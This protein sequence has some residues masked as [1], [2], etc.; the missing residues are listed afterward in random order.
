MKIS[1]YSQIKVASRNDGFQ[2]IS[3]KFTLDTLLFN[4]GEMISN[5]LLIKNNSKDTLRFTIDITHPAEWKSLLSNDK[6]FLILSGDS[7]YIPVRLLPKHTIKGSTRYFLSAFLTNLQGKNI[8]YAYFFAYTVKLVKWELSTQPGNKLYFLN[9]ENTLSFS[10]NVINTG[11]ENQDI[12]MQIKDLSYNTLLLDTNEKRI[13]KTIFSFRLD[14]LQDTSMHFKFQ[15]EKKPENYKRID[16]DYYNP[17]SI[18]EGKKYS[19][20]VQTKD[21]LTGPLSKGYTLGKKIEFIRLSDKIKVNDW[22]GAVLPLVMELNAY[23]LLN[24]VPMMNLDLR[25]N[26]MIGKGRLEYSTMFSYT[27]NYY[28][29]DVILDAPF[30]VSYSRENLSASIGRFGNGLGVTGMYNFSRNNSVSANYTVGPHLN[31]IDYQALGINHYFSYPLNNKLV[32]SVGI[33]TGLLNASYNP[34]QVTMQRVSVTPVVYIYKFNLGATVS[35]QRTL[36]KQNDS[37][38]YLTSYGLHGGYVDNFFNNKFRVNA[39]GQ[40]YNRPQAVINS[41]SVGYANTYQSLY[42]N[43]PSY[44]ANSQL[45]YLFNKNKR[46]NF[47]SNYDANPVYYNSV[48]SQYNKYFQN[49]L[50]YSVNV[51]KVN[52]TSGLFYHLYNVAGFKTHSRGVLLNSSKFDFLLFTRTYLSVNFGYNWAPS[53]S[54][55]NYFFLSQSLMTQYKTFY[56]QMFYTLGDVRLVPQSYVLKGKYSQTINLSVRY[57]YI[58]PIPNFVLELRNSYMYSSITGHSFAF[59]P[60]LYYFTRNGWRFRV[61]PEYFTSYKTYFNTAESYYMPTQTEVQKVQAK[62]YHSFNLSVGIRKEFGIPIPYIKSL[63]CTP[64]FLAYMDINGNMEYDKGEQLLENVVIR[65]DEYEV[66]TNEKGTAK[67]ENIGVGNHQI[68]TYSLVD[69][70]GWFPNVTDSVMLVVNKPQYIP[71][72][73]GIKI[74][75]GV[76]VE[77]EQYGA[78][79]DAPLDLSKIKINANN[80]KVHTALTDNKGN[81]EMYLPYGKYTLTFDESILGDRFRLIENNYELTIDKTVDNLYIPFYIVE[82]KRKISIKKFDEKGIEDSPD[83]KKKKEAEEKLRKDEEEK[84]RRIEP[85]EMKKEDELKNKKMTPAE[86]K[87]QAELEKKKKFEEEQLKKAELE[88]QKK[89]DLEN[90]KKLEEDKKIQEELD[91]KNKAKADSLKNASGDNELKKNKDGVIDLT[92]KGEV[93]NDDIKNLTDAILK[94]INGKGDKSSKGQ[95]TDTKKEDKKEDKKEE[96]AKKNIADLKNLNRKITKDDF[97]DIEIDGL[98]HRVQVAASNAEVP[99]SWLK[100]QFKIKGDVYLFKNDD[101]MYNYCLGDFT[102]KGEAVRYNEKLAVQKKVNSFI[103][104]YYNNKRVPYKVIEQ[105]YQSIIDQINE[106]KNTNSQND[107]LQ[108]QQSDSLKQL[109]KDTI[110]LMKD[111]LNK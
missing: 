6:Q 100:N 67:F 22:G 76:L 87:K 57:Q 66:I 18:E 27:K 110:K 38:D 75:G 46:I 35:G 52:F 40:F 25:G 103:S 101:G 86:K 88:K 89:L 41:F 61:S 47:S 4:K 92:A 78:T 10:T 82:K 68:I 106:E 3:C 36:Y 43:L 45:E 44:R 65:V 60:E 80:G 34:T 85:V 26:T 11:N 102:T 99:T 21:P 15:Y 37:T 62:F 14:P 63:F 33:N 16:L 70:E 12:V 91:K 72:S 17:F 105:I 83:L 111:T 53:L 31:N 51:N 55:K 48:S 58:F 96:V 64:E 39:S 71:F 84:K 97:L 81:Y 28:T 7:L 30:M 94:K 56:F 73:K 77:R 5:T 109:M 54:T 95:K 74:Y 49:Q 59:V 90:K 2:E 1:A 50:N 108:K 69:L 24:D 32:K 79:V 98:L 8:S 20:F 42:K 19:L 9:G 13:K 104:Y 107:N 93:N 29:S 23:N